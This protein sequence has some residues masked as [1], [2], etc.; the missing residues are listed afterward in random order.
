M[1]DKL[2]K[3][4]NHF[5]Y[6]IMLSKKSLPFISGGSILKENISHA[7]HS[8]AKVGENPEI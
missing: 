6:C 4:N 3:K 7:Y 5:C 2:L 8:A 1:A